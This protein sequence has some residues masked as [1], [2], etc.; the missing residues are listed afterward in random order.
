MISSEAG[1][2]AANSGAQQPAEAGQSTVNSSAS[3]PAAAF[4]LATPVRDSDIWYEHAQE[5]GIVLKDQECTTGIID[6]ILF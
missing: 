5:I 2:R 1:R 6:Q 3:A 4:C